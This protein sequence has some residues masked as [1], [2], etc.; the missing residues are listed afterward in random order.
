MTKR[1]DFLKIGALATPSLLLPWN[2]AYANADEINPDIFSGPKEDWSDI[3]DHFTIDKDIV[4]LN[5][6]TM[7]PSPK[8]VARA[9][10]NSMN[11]VNSKAHYGGWEKTT[12]VLA[13]YFGVA[14]DEICLTHNVTDGINII[15]QGLPLKSGDE[16]IV[17]N[18][19]HVGNALPWL[20]RARRDKL[21]VKVLDLTLEKN[22]LLDALEKLIGPKTRVIALPHIPC[23]NG[24]ISPVDEIGKLAKKHGLYYFLDGAHGPGML[25]LDL[26]KLNCDFYA[27]C[28]HKWM[29]APKGT[30]FLYIRKDKLEDIQPIFAGAYSDTGW[31]LIDGNPRIE[32]WAN[33]ASRFLNGTQNK[34]LYDGVIQAV[35]FHKKLGKTEIAK[36]IKTLNDRLYSKLEEQGGIKLITPKEERAGI[37]A[38]TFDKH[39]LFKFQRFC[40]E[41]NVIIRVVPENEINAVRVSTH[42]Y[43]SFEEIET[44]AQ[45]LR[46]FLHA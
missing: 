6:G 25:D 32:G 13:D 17:S 27:T 5:N 39:D 23:T 34:A 21:V 31:N 41:R 19:E 46:D 44:F 42:I 16:V 24:R 29:L 12:K 8:S 26:S 45:T 7:G 43:N 33:K 1:R 38:F 36:R 20:A 37:T 11:E 40:V 22:E 15:A 10:V 30:G 28:T 35:E 3:R 14:E 4:F 9:V 2:R 18:Q